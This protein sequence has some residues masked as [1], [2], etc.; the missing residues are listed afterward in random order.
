[1]LSEWLAFVSQEIYVRRLSYVL[2]AHIDVT[3]LSNHTTPFILFDQFINPGFN[4]QERFAVLAIM[5]TPVQ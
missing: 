3:G 2:S 4:H 5:G 1:M